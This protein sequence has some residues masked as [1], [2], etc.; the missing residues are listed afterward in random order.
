MSVTNNLKRQVDL[1][2]FEWMRPIP[3]ATTG[4]SAFTTANTLS[5]RY[6]YY[7]VSSAFYRYDTVTDSW[8]QL[9]NPVIAPAT[10]LEMGYSSAVGHYGRAISGGNN[11]IEMAALC[12][13]AL[14][15]NKIR[16]ISGTGAGQE[17]TITA[18]AQPVIKDRGVV[19]TAAT[20]VI[21]DA[22]TGVLIKQWKVNQYRDYQV[23]IHYGGGQSQVRPILYNSYNALTIYDANWSATTPWWGPVLSTTTSATAGSQTLYQI[24]S[25]IVTVDSNWTI[26]PDSTS[27][28]VVLAGGIWVISSNASTP[29]FS[30]QYYDVVSDMWYNKSC[31]SGLT[32]AAWSGDMTFERFTEAGGTITSGSV[33]TGSIR[34]ISVSDTSMTMSRYSNLELRITS[35]SGI[36]Q[37]RTILTNTTSSFLPTRDWDVAPDSSSLYSVYRDCG[38]LLL[39]GNA[40]ASMYQYNLDS[41]QWTTGKQLDFGTARH[42]SYTI[43]GVE[44]IA[45]SSIARTTGGITSLNSTPTVAGTGYLID[46]ILTITTGGTLGTARITGVNTVGGVTSVVLE[47]C[48]LTYTPGT[49]KATTVSPVGGTGCTLEI[50]SIGDI[51]TPTTA[52]SHNVEIGDVVSITGSIQPEYS[53]N[54]TI[55][56]TNATG[57]FQYVVTGTPVTPSTFVTQSST[58]M[59]DVNKNWV[60]NEHTGKL[61]QLSTPGPTAVGQVRRI[62]SNTQNTLTF[63]SA[64]AP[65]NGTS[66]YVIYDGKPFGTEMSIGGRIGGGRSGIATSGSTTSLVDSTKSWP[67]NCWSSGASRKVHIVAGT[68]VGSELSITSNDATTLNYTAQS[69]SPD[70]TT[71]YTIMDNFG[72]ATAGST[73]TLTDSTQNWGTNYWSGKR[74]KL[75][76]GTGQGNEYTITSNTATALTF[77]VATAPDTTTAYAILELPTRGAGIHID[78]ITGCSDSSCNNRYL[79]MWRGGATAELSRYDYTTE[80]NEMFTYFPITETLSTGSMYVYDGADRIYFTKDATGRIMSYDIVQNLVSPASTV[81]YGMSTAILG[82]RMEIIQTADGLKYLYIAR[83]TGQELWRTLLYW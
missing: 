72:M 34:N 83:H 39:V 44:P 33:T 73:S 27:Q 2:V 55:L 37:T 31:Q 60:V 70:G 30:L 40:A 18:V 67:V 51:A 64:S 35:G 8:Q 25:N 5:A 77:G 29:F 23:R 63:T 17:R 80:Q 75:L 49:G 4:V 68:G 9:A 76:S 6:I 36:G 61:V 14:V 24:E 22:S 19:T 46:Q 38:K 69:F 10:M 71:I 3:V 45:I 74:V 15:G 48:G 11:T 13:N 56:G 54:K 1:P 62:T 41:D 16:I 82:N 58:V 78:S 20:T 32:L 57:S 65:V 66:R 12:G 52:L 43:N 79:Y 81:P 53:G 59:V 7:L 47:S 28:F 42:M 50:V 21:T 26:N